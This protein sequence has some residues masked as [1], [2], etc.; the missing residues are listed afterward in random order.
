MPALIRSRLTKKS[1][2]VTDSNN[3]ADKSGTRPYPAW[4]KS[5]PDDWF[6]KEAYARRK[7]QRQKDNAWGGY[8]YRNGRCHLRLVRSETADPV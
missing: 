3:V 4:R 6:L 7:K 8:G 5:F 1:G 2:Y